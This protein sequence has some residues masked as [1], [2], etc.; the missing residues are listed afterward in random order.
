MDLPSSERKEMRGRMRQDLLCSLRWDVFAA[1]E[2][3]E[4]AVGPVGK[5]EF[6]PFFGS[7]YAN[8]PLG[9]LLPKR[10]EIHIGDLLSKRD[11]DYAPEEFRYKPP[12]PAILDNDEKSPVT[13][14]QFVTRAHE[15]FNAHKEEIIKTKRRFW[16]DAIRED[17]GVDARFFYWRINAFGND[18]CGCGAISIDVV[19]NVERIFNGFWERQLN[20]ARGVEVQPTHSCIPPWSGPPGGQVTGPLP[21]LYKP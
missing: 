4:I 11:F 17:K 13:V 18:E 1:L 9:Q 15:H 14:G 20:R 3:I 19:A 8:E 7:P 16:D 12:P 21:A 5:E 10:L 6:I 2:T